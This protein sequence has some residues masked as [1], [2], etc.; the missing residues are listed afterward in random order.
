MTAKPFNICQGTY[1]PL[2]EGVK[3][4]WTTRQMKYL[5]DN[6][7]DMYIEDIAKAVG[8]SALATKNKAFRMGCSIQSKPKVST[9]CQTM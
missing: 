1:A 5:L 2:S 7:K 3:G 4:T 8:K 6:H 9:K